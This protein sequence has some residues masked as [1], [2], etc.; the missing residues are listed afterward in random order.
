MTTDLDVL[1]IGRNCIDYIAVV[2]RFPAEDE[3]APLIERRI[4]G[5]GQGGTSSCCVA[6]LG[7]NVALAGNIGGDH[8]G[9]FCLQR[10]KDFNVL[11]DHIRV[12]DDAR[13]PMAYLFVTRSTGKRTIIYEPSKLP[14]IQIDD[15]LSQLIRRAKILSLDPQTT[16][17][18]GA[19]K[20]R[21]HAQP[22]IIY[23]CERWIDHIEEMMDTA[24]YFVPS[25]IFF[26]SR[27]DIFPAA[28]LVDNILILD[29]MTTGQVIVTH[30]SAGAFYPLHGSL[31]HVPAPVVRVRDTTGAGDNFHG[32][33]ALALSRGFTLHEAVKLAVAV[34]SLSCRGYGGRGALPDFEEA[35]SLSRT[36]E[37]HVISH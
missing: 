9:R 13:T 25:S 37:R 15:R 3:K 19:L 10:L 17:L 16:Y 24:D 4:E 27:P 12:L 26:K 8:E 35:S 29:N 6:R 7:G 31:H 32:A 22:S 2:E 28:D 33:F 21:A 5:G 34:A 30:G 20:Q 1:V 11:T 18:A 14:L 36:L 23:D